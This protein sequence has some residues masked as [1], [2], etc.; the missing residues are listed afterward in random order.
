MNNNG[1]YS[2]NYNQNAEGH[3]QV[4]RWGDDIHGESGYLPQGIE[5]K[6]IDASFIDM[7]KNEL[8]PIVKLKKQQGV[9]DEPMPVI[10][11]TNQRW[12]EFSKTYDLTTSEFKDISLPFMTLTRNNDIQIGTNQNGYFNIS[13][14]R[15]WLYFKVPTIVNGR[16]G[17]DNYK[18]PQPTPVDITFEL[19][20]FTSR[21]NDQNTSTEKILH[22]FNALQ[23]YIRVKG[24]PMPVVCEA[25]SDESETELEDRKLYITNYEVIIKGYILDESEFEVIPSLD[26]VRVLVHET[27]NRINRGVKNTANVSGILVDFKNKEI[28]SELSIGDIFIQNANSSL[29][30]SSISEFCAKQTI[31]FIG[32]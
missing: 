30:E 24:H 6:D 31:K 11:L 12:A 22:A 25:I 3:E 18:I 21:I 26:R 7:V 8:A 13:G 10:F 32:C 27:T 2:V 9:V 1:Q 4:N 28:I 19:R 16:K 17:F 29:I 5:I 23:K 20:V 14:K 15:N